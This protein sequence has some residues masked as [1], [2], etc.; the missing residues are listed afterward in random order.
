MFVFSSIRTYSAPGMWYLLAFCGQYLQFGLADLPA[1]CLSREVKESVL[2][3]EAHDGDSVM[4][5]CG[6]LE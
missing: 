2:E 6:V 1:L 3:V 4:L 5:S